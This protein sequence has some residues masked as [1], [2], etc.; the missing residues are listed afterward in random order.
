MNKPGAKA[1]IIYNKKLL[2]ILRDN[3]PNI[4]FPN[5]W[6]LPGGGIEEG[7]SGPEAIKRELQE[8]I[9]VIPKKILDLGEQ[10]FEDGSVVLRYLA[11]LTP[12]EYQNLKLGDE[13]QKLDF[14]SADETLKLDLAGHSKEY[15]TKYKNQIKEIVESNKIPEPELLGLAEH[16]GK[17]GG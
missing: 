14:F 15:F 1:F 4:S 16:S 3:N 17:I 9:N 11:R 6:N 12:D 10:T 7:E 2:W 5:T 8:E 13:G